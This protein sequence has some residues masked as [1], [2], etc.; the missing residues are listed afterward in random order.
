MGS[1]LLH[2]NFIIFLGLFLVGIEGFPKIRKMQHSFQAP[3]NICSLVSIQN[4]IAEIR[5]LFVIQPVVLSLSS[6]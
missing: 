1:S 2:S 6:K 5:N 3:L 4:H